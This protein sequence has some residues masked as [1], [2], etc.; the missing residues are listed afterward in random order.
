MILTYLKHFKGFNSLAMMQAV[1]FVITCINVFVTAGSSM[2]VQVV[3]QYCLA[4][5]VA[6]TL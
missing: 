4:S 3:S 1:D 5:Y 6:I 2:C